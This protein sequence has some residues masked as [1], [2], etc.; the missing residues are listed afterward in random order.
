MILQSM[1]GNPNHDVV[2]CLPHRHLTLFTCILHNII[3]YS[4]VAKLGHFNEVNIIDF[5]DLS[6]LIHGSP[7]NLCHV[8]FDLIVFTFT[9]HSHHVSFYPIITL[10]LQEAK[11]L[12]FNEL[13]VKTISDAYSVSRLC[14]MSFCQREDIWLHCLQILPNGDIDLGGLA[15]DV[16]LDVEQQALDANDTANYD[17]V[18]DDEEDQF[19]QQRD[20]GSFELQAHAT[21]KRPR[22]VSEVRSFIEPALTLDVDPIFAL[23]YEIVTLRSKVA[24]F[25]L[26]LPLLRRFIRL[27]LLHCTLTWQRFFNVSLH[28]PSFSFYYYLMYLDILYGFIL[29]IVWTLALIF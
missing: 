5:Y 8:I 9:H 3:R 25:I 26:S 2:I 7:I 24:V 13:N 19:D 1:T 15:L 23:T 17:S 28:L 14:A 10:M 20:R 12:L 11:V 4:L 16:D 18:Y 29:H 6:H 21:S 27:P 22:V